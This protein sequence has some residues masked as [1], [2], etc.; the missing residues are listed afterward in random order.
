M[1]VNLGT[2]ELTDEQRKAFRKVQGKSGLATRAEIAAVAQWA[3]HAA[4]NYRPVDI[5]QVLGHGERVQQAKAFGKA[6]QPEFDKAERR[7]MDGPKCRHCGEIESKGRHGNRIN[8]KLEHPFEPLP[9][10][11]DLQEFGG[12]AVK[13]FKR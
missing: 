10:P 6:F 5:G 4:L 1:K 2:I 3:V 11:E 13:A 8:G 12:L 9:W 7:A